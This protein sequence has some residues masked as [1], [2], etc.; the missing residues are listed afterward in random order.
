MTM[1][2]FRRRG[3]R[4]LEVNLAGDQMRAAT[5]AMVA[6]D[7]EVKFKNAGFGGGEGLRAGLKR[8]ATASRCR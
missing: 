1:A 3:N 5:G 2:Q 4:V 8:K 7:G 6:Y